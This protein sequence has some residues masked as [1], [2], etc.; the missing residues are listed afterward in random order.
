MTIIVFIGDNNVELANLAKKH[1]CTAFLVTSKNVERFLKSTNSQTIYTSHADLPKITKTSNKLYEVLNKADKIYYCPPIR[2]SDSNRDYNISSQQ[3][4]IEFLLTIIH[5]EKNNV[6][7]YGDY[8]VR[9]N[10]Y[11]K[12]KETRSTN[13]PVIWNAGCSIADGVGVDNCERYASIISKKLKIDVVFL[14]Q[15]GTGIDYSAD[16]I[17]RSDI[18][19]NDIILWGLTQEMRQ[20]CWL[21]DKV[22]MNFDDLSESRLY[23]SLTSVHQVTNYCKKVNATLIMFPTI[24][25][26]K[27][28]LALSDVN[29]YYEMPYQLK[30]IDYGT[31]N[32]HPG[33]MQ[34]KFWAEHLLKILPK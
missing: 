20:S 26:E 9:F 30:P 7:N 15:G 31:D 25:T 10:K 23:R 24:C 22:A 19:E 2:W 6:C 21:D 14:S 3:D 1:D 27:F 13:K 8:S 4:Q 11:L 16:Q 34:H 28:R 17:L 12:L 29:E 32:L 18:K 5:T 33:P